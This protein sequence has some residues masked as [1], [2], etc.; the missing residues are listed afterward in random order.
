MNT[1]MLVSMQ[2]LARLIGCVIMLSGSTTELGDFRV[3]FDY[4]P[5]LISKKKEKLYTKSTNWKLFGGAPKEIR[6]RK[7][8]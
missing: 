5:V 1:S 3:S 8:G 7:R 2:D 6:K 4:K